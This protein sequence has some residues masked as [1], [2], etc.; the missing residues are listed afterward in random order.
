MRMIQA[1]F[2]NLGKDG[3]K[4]E[5]K[6]LLSKASYITALALRC[7]SSSLLPYDLQ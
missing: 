3:I 2:K 6:L 1:L 4:K 7:V 5:I